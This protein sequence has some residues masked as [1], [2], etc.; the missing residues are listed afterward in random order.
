MNTIEQQLWDYIDGNLTAKQAK[1]IEEKIAADR[2]VKLLYEQILQ[3]DGFFGKL[4][5]DAPSMSF[6]RNI[7]E[8]VAH[9]PAPV[10]LKTRVNTRIIYGIGGFFIISLLALFGYALFHIDFNSVNFYIKSNTDFN[11]NKYITPTIL[12]SFLFADLVIGL[13][14]LDYLLRKTLTHK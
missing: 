1:T 11:L 6:T 10:A 5:I 8:S 7:M 2:S 4:E 3:L 12:Y 14:F 9:A 13:V